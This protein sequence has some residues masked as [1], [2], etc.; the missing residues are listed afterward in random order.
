[1]FVDPYLEALMLDTLVENR[2]GSSWDDL[3]QQAVLFPSQARVLMRNLLV[4]I[5]SPGSITPAQHD[6]FVRG[7][8]PTPAF[9][10]VGTLRYQVRHDRALML[11]GERGGWQQS[12]EALGR[13][14]S[15]WRSE[16]SI[17]CQP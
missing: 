6:W 17:L 5:N 4:P 1:V 9:S 11:I 7:K 16:S 3:N 15:W 13:R 8:R 10:V 12:Y 14:E 2:V